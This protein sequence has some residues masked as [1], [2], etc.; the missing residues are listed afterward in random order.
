MAGPT[1]EPCPGSPVPTREE[2][3]YAM[4]C[5]ILAIPA[6]LVP[7][8]HI[9]A[10]LVIW[11]MKRE[12]SAFV[13]NQGR[14]AVNFQI[15]ITIAFIVAGLLCFV[16]VGMLLVPLVAL[17]WLICSILAAVRANDGIAYRYP[18]TIRLIN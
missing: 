3:T 6:T 16:F 7:F 5:H 10:P 2:R 13:D 17:T 18:F 9:V 15:T 14:E 11:L 4:L 12:S 8:G 1:F